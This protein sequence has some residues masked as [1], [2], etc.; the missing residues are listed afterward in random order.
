MTNCNPYERIKTTEAIKTTEVVAFEGLFASDIGHS[1]M[2]VGRE[3]S[4]LY[5]L[6]IVS[7]SVSLELSPEVSVPYPEGLLSV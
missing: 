1:W 2:E 7:M 5:S 3:A 4:S 6:T